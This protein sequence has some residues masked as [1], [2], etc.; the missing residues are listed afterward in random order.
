M[1]LHDIAQLVHDID[2]VMARRGDGF[3]RADEQQQIG[4]HM[5]HVFARASHFDGLPLDRLTVKIIMLQRIRKTLQRL[6]RLDE[7]F[8]NVLDEGFADLAEPD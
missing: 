4:N 7:L 6:R 2:P 1:G 5:L 3:L 8:R